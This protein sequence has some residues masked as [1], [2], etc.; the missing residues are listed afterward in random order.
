LDW[1]SFFGNT[2][3][4][5]NEWYHLAFV[6]D[7]SKTNKAEIYVNGVLDAAYT[8]YDYYGDTIGP[9]NYKP[10]VPLE[11]GK[12]EI[13]DYEGPFYFKGLMDEVQIY[14]RALTAEEISTIYSAGS[15]ASWWTGD[16]NAEDIIG[17]NNGTLMGGTTFATGKVEQAFSFDGQDDWVE[18]SDD[19][20]LRSEAFTIAA[21]VKIPDYGVY[22]ILNNRDV[23][24]GNET[25]N[26]GAG[27]SYAVYPWQ[28]GIT[29]KPA[30]SVGQTGWD[31]DSFLGN[32]KLNLNEW[33][34]LAFVFDYSKTN[35]AEIYVNGALDAAYTTYD[36]YGDTIGPVNYKPGVP[37]EIG[38]CETVNYEGP[39]YFKGLMDE[40]Q[41]YN[42]ALTD[43]EIEAIY[44]VGM[45]IP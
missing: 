31:W 32:T 22:I 35:K 8:T 39:F 23:D 18:V 37:L 28:T 14:N 13:A 29:G 2:K 12:Y 38:K 10:G 36:Y 5:L 34:H 19:A 20:S 27:I 9:V 26:F 33:Y 4:N 6:F 25:F 11:I 24:L 40:V 16:G 7:Y 42:R 44:S 17:G 43:E 15:L 3:L 30:F 1:D 41:L 45:C 21:W